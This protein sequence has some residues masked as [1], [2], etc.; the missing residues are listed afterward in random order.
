MASG[1]AR[2]RPS[3]LVAAGFSKLRRHANLR[4]PLRSL[5]A[6]RN[7]GLPSAPELSAQFL[8]PSQRS[9]R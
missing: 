1:L 9:N 6:I 7:F 4:P 5:V 2:N 8:N 3:G